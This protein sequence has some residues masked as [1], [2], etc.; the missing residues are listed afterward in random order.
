MDLW[1]A[2]GLLVNDNYSTPT[3]NNIYCLSSSTGIQWWMSCRTICAGYTS[4][5]LLVSQAKPNS[6]KGRRLAQSA[7]RRPLS[8]S[9]SCVWSQ[10]W[11]Q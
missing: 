1:D 9:H 3:V 7:S 11:A 10:S 2:A 8:V 5:S 4:R 6:N